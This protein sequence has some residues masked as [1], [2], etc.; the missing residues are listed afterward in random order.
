MSTSFEEKRQAPRMTLDADFCEVTPAS[1]GP[2]QLAIVRDISQGGL[3]LEFSCCGLLEGLEPG[4]EVLV[5]DMPVAWA[6]LAGKTFAG[7]VAWRD[8]ALAGIA[9]NEPLPIESPSLW[10]FRLLQLDLLA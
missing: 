6:G 7:R 9:L 2:G 8:G 3:K 4:C 5:G 10:S 1:G